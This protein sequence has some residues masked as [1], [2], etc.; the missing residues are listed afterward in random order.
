MQR[1]YGIIHDGRGGAWRIHF[2]S[3]GWVF[4]QEEIGQHEK[5]KIDRIPAQIKTYLKGE[6]QNNVKIFIVLWQE[7][8][9]D[10]GTRIC[11]DER[12]RC[13]Q[14]YADYF[15]GASGI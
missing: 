3:S 15:S 12:R 14:S 7:F 1:G 11:G 4:S 9:P 2:Q 13:N 8:E 6:E 10:F 5:N